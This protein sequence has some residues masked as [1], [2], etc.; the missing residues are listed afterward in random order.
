M[1][2]DEPDAVRW[3]FEEWRCEARHLRNGTV[4][5]LVFH[6][7]Q[8]LIRERVTPEKMNDRAAELHTMAVAVLSKRTQPPTSPES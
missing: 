4:A 7:G 1:T 3:R 2:V 5:L 8:L 6:G